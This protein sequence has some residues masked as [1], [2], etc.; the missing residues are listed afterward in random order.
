M[1]FKILKRNRIRRHQIKSY[2]VQTLILKS[3]TVRE[4]KSPSKSSKMKS[5]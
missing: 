5:P 2:K 3:V 4:V 1:N